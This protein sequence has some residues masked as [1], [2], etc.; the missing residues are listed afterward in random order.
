[1][2]KKIKNVEPNIVHYLP[3]EC[4]AREHVGQCDL[5]AVP[6]VVELLVSLQHHG[7]AQHHSSPEMCEAFDS[8][9]VLRSKDLG[10]GRGNLFYFLSFFLKFNLNCNIFWT[11]SFNRNFKEYL[12][13][14]QARTKRVRLYTNGVLT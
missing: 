6:G 1:M 11:R 8:R 3:L 9:P 5:R 4:S 13:L 10:A 2:S 7:A 12:R 14:T